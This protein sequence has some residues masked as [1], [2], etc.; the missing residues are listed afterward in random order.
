MHITS[1]FDDWIKTWLWNNYIEYEDKA[2]VNPEIAHNKEEKGVLV[3][4]ALI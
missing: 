3:P 1:P 2:P 4:T